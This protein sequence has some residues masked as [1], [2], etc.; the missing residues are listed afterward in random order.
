MNNDD[1]IY[2]NYKINNLT[3]DYSVMFGYIQNFQ[4]H[5]ENCYN[6]SIINFVAK[7]N[8]LKQLNE[9]VKHLNLTYNSLILTIDNIT[10]NNTI[11]TDFKIFLNNKNFQSTHTFLQIYNTIIKKHD[12]INFPYYDLIQTLTQKIAQPIGF[13]SIHIALSMLINPNYKYFFDEHTNNMLLFYNSV[14]TPLSFTKTKAQIDTEPITIEQIELDTFVLLH[15]CAKI[16]IKHDDIIISLSG[17]FVFDSLNIVMRTSELCN[18]HLYDKKTE[19]GEIIK[20]MEIINADFAKS[21]IRHAPLC[22]IIVMTPQKFADKVLTDYNL[23]NKLFFFNL[24]EIMKEFIKEGVTPKKCLLNMFNIIKLLLLGNKNEG[25]N[26]AEVLFSITEEKKNVVGLLSMSEIIYKNLNHF[27]QIKLKKTSRNINIEISKLKNLDD[28]LIEKQIV[29]STNMPD[30]VKKLAMEKSEELKHTGSDHYKQLLYVKTLLNYPWM[31]ISNNIE[32]IFPNVN[33][34]NRKLFLDNIMEGM[35]KKVCGHKECKSKIKE[36]VGKWIINPSGSGSVIGLSGP[37]GVGKT[38]IAKAIGDVLGLPF[39]Q[40]NLGGQNDG[41]LLYGHGYSY[42]SAQPGLI[43]KKMID[44][45][46]A[47]CIMYFDELDKTNSR[48]GSNEITNILIHLT[49]PMTNSE[50]QDRFFQGVNFPLNKVLFIFSYNDPSSI[51]KILLDRIEQIN[52]GAFK[53]ADKKQIVHKFVIEEMCNMICLDSKLV[54]INDDVIEFIIETYTNEAGIRQLKRKFEKIFLKLN[55]DKIYQ[56]NIFSENS[57]NI[58]ITK[59]YVELCLGNKVIDVQHINDF[60]M[61]GVINGL[62]ATNSGYGGILPIQ[63]YE[64]YMNE[65]NGFMVKMTGSQKKVMRESVTCALSVA[66]NY[67]RP[68]IRNSYMHNNKFGFHLHAP[69]GATPKDGPSA[70]AAF[71]VAFVSRLLNKKI[72]R[73]VAVTGEIDLVG[74]VTKIGGLEYKLFGAKKAGI[75]LV[76]VS[77]ENEDDVKKIMAE[78]ADLFVNFEVKLVGELFDVLKH[79]IVD[80][81]NNDVIC[82]NNKN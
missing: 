78:Y 56:T 63:V 73:N 60:D 10:D 61:V 75:K 67:V 40:I 51:D 12:K 72:K 71:S 57:N 70:G 26:I 48:N 31:S 43:V 21:Y 82:E 9:C 13:S 1:N 53:L 34:K 74:N 33:E 47:R 28:D 52:I 45:G 80:F 2:K 64:N 58:I 39:V 41:E 42:S 77:K 15:N 76:L 66:L 11:E 5:I 18:K 27:L 16:N 44:A 65:N 8:Y 4:S 20:N 35:E 19:I 49:D 22:D 6:N 50:F 59:E 29:I 54:T 79:M 81:D 37:P 68:D 17:Y 23:Y 36:I 55:I 3:E 25:V 62:F 14:F 24:N 69:D 7:N 38:L 30:Y 46:K 32:P